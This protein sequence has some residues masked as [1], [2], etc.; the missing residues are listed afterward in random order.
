YGNSSATTT[1]SGSN[2]F[3]VFDDFNDLSQWTIQ[4]GDWTIEDGTAKC[5]SY[6]GE[7]K[8]VFSHSDGAIL[9]RAKLSQAANYWRAIIGYRSTVDINQGYRSYWGYI[10]GLGGKR[11]VIAKSEFG[12]WGHMVYADINYS[13]NNWY[14]AEA[15]FA[16]SHHEFEFNREGVP[17][18]TTDSFKLSDSHVFIQID[19][20]A[21]TDYPVWYDWYAFRKYV[22]PEPQHGSWSSEFEHGIIRVPDNYL[23]IQEA[24]NSANEG[25][26]VFVRNGIHFE[27]IVVNK[28]ISLIGESKNETII[29]GENIG[30]VVLITAN[31]VNITNFTVRNSG[32]GWDPGDMEHT[33][34]YLYYYH[35]GITISN[36][37]VFSSRIGIKVHSS[38]STVCN[39]IAVNNYI[40]LQ[41]GREAAHNLI[42]GNHIADNNWSGVNVYTGSYDNIIKRNTVISNPIGIEGESKGNNRIFHNNFINNNLQRSLIESAIWDNGCEGNYWS[43]Y[44]GSDLDD[45]G[46]GDTFLPWEGVDS[47]PLMNLYW[48]PCDINHDL[49]VD[50]KDIASAALAYGSE[51]G[52]PN[53]NPHADVSGPTLFE[54]DGKVNI[55]D[56]ALIARDFGEEYNQ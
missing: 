43:N 53:W 3:L 37:N 33:G 40:G 42:Y 45:D 30:I 13:V 4:S 19:G 41:I 7:I 50:I 17:T 47:Y 54:P 28:S 6:V 39:N 12:S 8:K 55:R 1:S 15:R 18:T 38:S 26:T 21:S 27:S 49:K 14:V 51:V 11:A 20:G 9:Y 24:V 48:N 52:D 5:T 34:I 23:T 10:S 35:T 36:N 44:N 22:K 29:D 56:I 25:D 46:I 31:N 32:S 16:D 2:T